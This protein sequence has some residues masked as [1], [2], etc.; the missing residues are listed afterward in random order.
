ML[1]LVVNDMIMMMMMMTTTMTSR[2]LT[3]HRIDDLHCP[4]ILAHR[5]APKEEM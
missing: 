4:T 2:L 5:L 1:M 3:A